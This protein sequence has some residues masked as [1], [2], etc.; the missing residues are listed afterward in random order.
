MFIEEFFMK[1]RPAS[2]V[3]LSVFLIIPALAIAQEPYIGPGIIT[4]G[5]RWATLDALVGLAS[6]I[7]ATMSL[8]R[9]T[10]RFGTGI[11]RQGAIFAGLVGLMVIA[12]AGWHLSIFTGD[13]G[14]GSGRAGAIIA[15]VMGLI[16]ILIAGVTL[17]R[18]RQTY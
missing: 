11:G 13:F 1:L 5:R 3:V 17:T 9:S 6:T 10:G 16:S 7:L 4:D 15:I 14:S 18:S 2:L 8:L 12:Y